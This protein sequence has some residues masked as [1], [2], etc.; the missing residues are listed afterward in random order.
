MNE[1]IV[2]DLL[3]Q[4]LLGVGEFALLV[5]LGAFVFITLDTM[6]DVIIERKQARERDRTNKFQ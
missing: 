6:F 2:I 5:V 4:L 1:A 3:I